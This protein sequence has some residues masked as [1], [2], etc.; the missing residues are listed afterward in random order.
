MI[1]QYTVNI[2]MVT[3]LLRRFANT[4]TGQFNGHTH[5]DIFNLYY[6]TSS[7]TPQAVGVAFNGAS[8]VTF[9]NNNPSFKVYYADA[10]TF[11]SVE[12]FLLDWNVLRC[13]YI[14]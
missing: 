6:N 13:V 14:L 1:Q 2:Y 10:S 3:L 4:I 7:A 12:S 11:V 8:V 5:S 9:T